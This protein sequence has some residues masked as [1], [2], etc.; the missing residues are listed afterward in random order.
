M[1][2][3]TNMCMKYIYSLTIIF[4]SGLV[5]TI[6]ISKFTNTFQ[7]HTQIL[8][9][10]YYD[11]SEV[12]KIPQ[13]NKQKIHKNC[14]SPILGQ[15]GQFNLIP[16]LSLPGSGNTWTRYLLEQATGYQTGSVYG[17]PSL[18]RGLRRGHF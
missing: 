13:N 15:S 7:K 4:F 9:W 16:L 12:S 1:I 14:S 10:T 8:K 5:L 2:N 18:A 3:P 11:R 6:I 17:D